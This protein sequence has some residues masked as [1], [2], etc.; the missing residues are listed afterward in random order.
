MLYGNVDIC[1]VNI[2]FCVG[3]RLVL[4]NVDEGDIIKVG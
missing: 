1:I 3:G 2:S 4:L